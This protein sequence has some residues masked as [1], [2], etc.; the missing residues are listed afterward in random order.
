MAQTHWTTAHPAPAKAAQSITTPLVD[1]LAA[2]LTTLR[3]ERTRLLKLGRGR[4]KGIGMGPS[5]CNIR[6]VKWG[7]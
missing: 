1:P 6:T 7:H 4:G 3:W 2:I 5:V